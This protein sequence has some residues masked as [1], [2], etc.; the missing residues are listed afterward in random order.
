[1]RASRDTTSSYWTAPQF[2]VLDALSGPSSVING[3][4]W[5]QVSGSGGSGYIAWLKQDLS[6]PAA[7]SGSD[8]YWWNVTQF[9]NS[10]ASPWFSSSPTFIYIDTNPTTYAI[11]PNPGSVGEGAGSL[12]FTVTRSGG[13]PSETIYASTTQTEGY[14]NNGDYT[15]F[16]NQNVAFALNQTQATVS[17]WITDDTSVESSETF[18]L[19]VQRNASDPITTYLA[20]TTF[21]IID[22]DTNPTTYAISPNP[23]SVGEGAGSL[24]FTVTRSGGLPSETIYASTTQTEGYSNNGDY[25]GFVNQNVA[26]ALNQ[27]QATVSVWITDDTSVESSETFGLIVQR[28]ASDPITTYLAKTTFTIIDNDTN[29]TTYAI[30]PNPGSV[31]EGAGSLS[32][33]VTRSGGLPSETIYAS[34]TQTEGYSNNGDYTGFVN[35]NV[36]FALNQTQATVSVWITDDTSVESSETFGLIVQRNASDPITTYL[37]KTTFTIIDNDTNPTTYA[38]SPNPGSVGEGAGSLSFTVTRS[39][40]LPS[41]TIYASTTQTEGY[42]NNGDY[43]GFVNQNVAFAL[44]QTQATVSVWITDDTSVESS[45]T[46]GLI[47]QR[48]ASDPITT[49]L[50]KTTF[51]IIDNDTNPS[52]SGILGIDV[53]HNNGSGIDWVQVHNSGKTFAWVKATGGTSD[54][55]LEKMIDGQFEENM[56]SGYSAGMIMGAY[57]F[58]YPQSYTAV[59]EADH[60]VAVAGHYITAGYLRPALDLEND[61]ANNSYPYQLGKSILSQWILDWANE[62]ELLT[63]VAPVIYT[64]RDYARNYLDDS[65]NVYPVWIATVSGDPSADP[66]NLGIWSTWAFQQ[67]DWHGVCPGVSTEVDFDS[68]NGDRTAFDAYVISPTGID[69]TPPQPNP[70]TWSSA[71]LAVG[72]DSITMTAT[73]AAD[74]SGMEYFFHET[75]GHAGSADSGWQDS[76]TFLA[77]S[78]SPSTDYAYQVKARDKSA[79]H[80]ETT[81]SITETATTLS[82]ADTTPPQP[83]PMTWSSAPAAAGP[84]SITMTATAAADTSGIE[85]FFHETTGHAGSADSGWQDSPTFL[86]TSL[87]PSTDYAYQV[88]ARDKSANHNETTY[89]N[90]LSATTTAQTIAVPFVTG[91]T[92]SV[93]EAAIVGAGLT[94]GVET[95]EWSAMVP[96]GSVISETPTAGTLVALGSSVALVISK[97]PAPTVPGAPTIGTATAG[98]AQATVTFSAPFS[99]GGSAIT[100]YTATSS[101]GAMTA[102]GSASPLTVTGLTNGTAYTFTVTAT[103][104][105]GTGPASAAS[106]SVTVTQGGEGE[107]EGEGESPA[108]FV[109]GDNVSGV[110]DGTSWPTAFTT[111]QVAVNTAYEAGGGEVWVA[112]GTYTRPDSPVVTM[113]E[114]VALYGGFIGLGAGGEE[115]SRGQRNWTVHVTSISGQGQRRCVIGASN[116]SLDGFSLILGTS[117]DSYANGGGMYNDSSSPS[118][119]NCVFT[120]NNGR[121]MYNNSSSPSVTNCVFTGNTAIYGGGGMYNVSSSP[122]VT[123][124]VF[125]NNTSDIGGGGMYNHV[126]SAPTVTNCVFTSN[127]GPYG[128]G[129]TNDS[130]SP[131]ITNC[132]FT[133]N[134]GATGGGIYDINSSAPVVENSI[135]WGN[136]NGAISGDTPTVTYSCVEGGWAGTGNISDNPLFV[137]APD[138]LHLQAGSPCIDT[139]TADGAPAE[140]IEDTARPQGAGFDM[141]AYEYVSDGEGEDGFVRVDQNQDNLISLSELLRI[142]QFFNSDGFHCQTGTEDGYA[143]GPG[144][145]TCSTYDSDYNPQDWHISLSELLRVIQFF[146]S[147]GYHYCPAE[148]TEDGFCPGPLISG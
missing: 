41:E 13:L 8:N 27:T 50:A 142:I 9:K 61:P 49:Y 22:N 87:S 69:T 78:L 129:M 29:P 139:G 46:F 42:S 128:G 62:V 107:G 73:A 65:L 91:I 138:D 45:E 43:T 54:V 79:N 110:E 109:D 85:Y 112:E 120:G 105:I 113:R 51:T 114:N 94:V 57:H 144:D 89:S 130:S 5:I 117:P 70:M 21:T 47:V 103:N 115:Q 101:P 86:A 136:T 125:T 67:Y 96:M 84:T 36:A 10:A 104:A 108:W 75:T 15:G 66:G 88:K 2:S 52:F 133:S 71:P 34:T 19:I 24:S 59:D 97:G 116:A 135:V 48:N 35:Q 28:N 53:S 123:N 56:E 122:A 148:G 18:G 121:G 93:A 23:G 102:T 44:N 4:Q 106:N 64:D 17:V 30:S 126:F 137:S 76:P 68:F 74:T 25:T 134:T 111:I 141:G 98:D 3:Y 14:S 40:G 95:Q 16:V 83:N 100:S 127:T 82:I 63:G 132:V 90:A 58:A 11:S 81:Y 31:G 140:D 39:G 143:P 118:V 145:E 80:N 26:F 77:T 92:L 38:I 124:C 55:V 33:T 6:G 32:F 7:T 60:F 12:S 146:N 99:D 72:P 147:G 131:S 1:M 37:A 20:K 119:T